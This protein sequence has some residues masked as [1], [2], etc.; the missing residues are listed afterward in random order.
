MHN[1]VRMSAPSTQHLGSA[2]VCDLLGVDR[3]TLVR[4]V[5]R[6]RIVP[7]FKLPGSNG[8]YVYDRTEIERLRDRLTAGAAS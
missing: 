1:A 7:A 3:S 6:E 8:A 5:Q 4:W 2:A